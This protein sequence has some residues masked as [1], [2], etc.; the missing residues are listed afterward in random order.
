MDIKK[1]PIVSYQAYYADDH[2]VI[3]IEYNYYLRG[4]KSRNSIYINKF[5]LSKVLLR[6]YS[7]NLMYK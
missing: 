4:Y 7:Y 5:L 3:I 2:I 6:I 1:S